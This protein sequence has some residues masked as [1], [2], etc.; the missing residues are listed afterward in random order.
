MPLASK[1]EGHLTLTTRERSRRRPNAWAN[2]SGGMRDKKG[3]YVT[4]GLTRKDRILS[5]SDLWLKSLRAE[6][7]YKKRLEV[8]N[9]EKDAM[10]NIM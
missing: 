5:Y 4:C 2:L 7:T 6:L 9:A 3:F 8:R 1:W 10:G